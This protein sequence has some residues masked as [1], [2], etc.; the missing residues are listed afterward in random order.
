MNLTIIQKKGALSLEHLLYKILLFI[1]SNRKASINKAIF[2]KTV[3]LLKSH[4]IDTY[5]SDLA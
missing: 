5:D 2:N 4:K 3:Q 1:H